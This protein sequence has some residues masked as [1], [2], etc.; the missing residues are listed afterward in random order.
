MGSANKAAQLK[1]CDETTLSPSIF[2]I[3]N[4]VEKQPF[5]N[6]PF[7]KQKGSQ[8]SMNS[9]KLTLNGQEVKVKEIEVGG[10]TLSVL[11]VI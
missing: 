8:I 11:Q 5:P 9:D 4:F 7:I 1:I 10:E 3:K 6:A 2:E